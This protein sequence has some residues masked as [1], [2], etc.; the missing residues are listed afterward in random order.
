MPITIDNLKTS[1]LDAKKKEYLDTGYA[2]FRP[3]RYA[4]WTIL[5][6]PTP[7]ELDESEA[8]RELEFAAAKVRS[9]YND[10]NSAMLNPSFASK[11]TQQKTFEQALKNFYS[12]FCTRIAFF[13]ED[14]IPNN[15]IE[16]AAQFILN[17]NDHEK[18]NT[19][20]R[21]TDAVLMLNLQFYLNRINE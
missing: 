10:L 20:Q 21:I 13:P 1:V 19:K 12:K 11:T 18:N 6:Q 8:V 5:P 7:E 16:L 4:M 2:I 15:K 14:R 3:I 9:A 17:P